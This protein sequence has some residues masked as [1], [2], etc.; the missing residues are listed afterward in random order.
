MR[1]VRL[2]GRL[3]FI[4]GEADYPTCWS[5]AVGYVIHPWPWGGA[6]AWDQLRSSGLNHS[7]GVVIP[8]PRM[9]R[10]RPTAAASRSTTTL[11]ASP[12]GSQL[13]PNLH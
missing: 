11:C 2:A 3:Y 12:P 6:P 1:T 9:F 8:L 13:T 4:G 7:S 5:G 10:Q